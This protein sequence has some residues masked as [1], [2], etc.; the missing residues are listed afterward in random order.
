MAIRWKRVA[1]E[2]GLRSVV[3]ARDGRGWEL[4]DTKTGRMFM[5]VS[6]DPPYMGSVEWRFWVVSRGASVNVR[7]IK[8]WPTVEAAHAAASK[9]WETV[10]KKNFAREA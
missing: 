1:K 8:S 2:T 5:F 10:G 3:Q 7:S 4:K 6:K 9:W